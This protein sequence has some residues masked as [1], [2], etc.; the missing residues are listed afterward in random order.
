[1][2]VLYPT[3]LKH[4]LFEMPIFLS[5]HWPIFVSKVQRVLSTSKAPWDASLESVLP[6]VHSR[7]DISNHKHDTIIHNQEL[8]NQK[9]K[10]LLISLSQK[11]K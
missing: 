2:L 9:K 8:M 11:K 4:G 7:L 6:G 10:L 5:P 3:R 1:M